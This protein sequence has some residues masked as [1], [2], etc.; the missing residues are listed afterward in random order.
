MEQLRTG[1]QLDDLLQLLLE[2]HLQ[3]AV[4]LV[5]DQTLQVLEHEAGGVLRTQRSA[6]DHR[7]QTEAQEQDL[8]PPPHLE[9]VQ[10]TARRGHQDVDP[11]G[12]LLGL[13]RAVAAAHD[14]AVGVDVV[15]HQLLHHAVRL[16]GQLTRGRQDHHAG[17][18]EQQQQQLSSGQFNTSEDKRR[19]SGG[20]SPF[21]GMNLSL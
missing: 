2:A 11:I 10:Q 13:G 16:H 8:T 21:L 7:T 19:T 1:Q 20:N 5:D 4:G 6:L 15:G 17:A 14:E 12:Q 3:D 18:W 9:V